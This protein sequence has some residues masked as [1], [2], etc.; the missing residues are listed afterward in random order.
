VKFSKLI[1]STVSAAGLALL[2]GAS[3][4]QTTTKVDLGKQEYNASCAVCHGST[5]K[6]NGPYTPLLK[7]APPDMTQ[8][9][10]QNGGVLP[11]NRLYEM[12]EGIGVPSHGTRDMPIWGRA[13]RLQAGEYYVDTPY[14]AEAF[15]RT[16][17]LSL[18]E[19]INR[20]QMK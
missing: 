19:Y 13:Y 4:A 15:V 18:V 16:R 9:A 11:I 17:I 12:I 6:G 5:G 2:C 1:Y 20:L 7:I 14:D 10:K 8:L 3:L